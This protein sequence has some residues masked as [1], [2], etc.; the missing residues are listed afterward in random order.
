MERIH[1]TKKKRKTSESFSHKMKSL[2][3]ATNTAAW[4]MGSKYRGFCPLLSSSPS[5]SPRHLPS[6]TRVYIV[7]SSCSTPPQDSSDPSPSSLS[8]TEKN[9]KRK[10]LD[11][12][13]SRC[14]FSSSPSSSSSPH[15]PHSNGESHMQ[16]LPSVDSMHSKSSTS[17]RDKLHLTTHTPSSLSFSSSHSREQGLHTNGE[18]EVFLCPR[19]FYESF[20]ATRTPA[21]ILPGSDQ[22]RRYTGSLSSTIPLEKYSS[23]S[24]TPSSSASLSSRNEPICASSSWL[25]VSSIQR[26]WLNIE[27]DLKRRAGHLYV[28]VEERDPKGGIDVVYGQGVFKRCRFSTFLHRLIHEGD[29]SVYLTTQRLKH[30]RDGPKRLCG[31][32]LTALANDFPTVPAIFGN[33]QPYQYN[34]WMGHSGSEE[35]STTGL[36]HDFHDNLYILLQ[37]RKIFR[38]FSPRVAGLLPTKGRIVSVHPNGLICYSEHIREDGAHLHNVRR[39]QQTVL[40]EKIA[41]LEERLAAVKEKRKKKHSGDVQEEQEDRGGET[42]NENEEENLQSQLIEAE[43]QLDDMLEL[44][45]QEAAADGE[46]VDEGDSDSEFTEGGEDEEQDELDG[47]GDEGAAMGRLFKQGEIPDHF[48]LENTDSRSLKNHGKTRRL[49]GMQE[50]EGD[51]EL[52]TPENIF[53]YSWDVELNAG[54]MLY[55]PAGWF[56]EVVSF[57]SSPP[58]PKTPSTSTS[59]S[60]SSPSSQVKREDERNASSFHMALNY[61]VHPPVF[62][63][64]FDFPYVDD[65]WKCRTEPLLAAHQRAMMM[66]SK[67]IGRSDA[68]NCMASSQER[69]SRKIDEAHHNSGGRKKISMNE[70][71]SRKS[72]SSVELSKEDDTP[73]PPCCRERKE[74]EQRK[75]DDR[76]RRRLGHLLSHS[77]VKEDPKREKKDVYHRFFTAWQA[78]YALKHA[79]RRS[80]GYRVPPELC[81]VFDS[82]EDEREKR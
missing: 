13:C 63:S 8:H 76:K 60:P 14:S 74:K 55:L 30:N 59:S 32:P 24:T 47:Q 75:E 62:N 27:K 4:K 58:S 81:Y 73:S 34:V 77:K 31:A 1:K 40:E 10:A 26:K 15:Q 17:T 38:L 45:L 46:D 9:T 43:S 82:S 7:S 36:H 44:A 61:W 16:P 5:Y 18:K 22:F 66:M 11:L 69:A 37:G 67:D 21:I 68:Q 79:G 2:S 51:Q 33:L 25:D 12:L 71:R 39:W 72:D 57:S 65:Y 19:C 28:D 78:H 49:L 70:E 52:I 29:T 54:E 48:C 41:H 20:I 56:H 53:S 23:I 64:S 80:G 3:Q 50:K 35:G 42:N 6:V